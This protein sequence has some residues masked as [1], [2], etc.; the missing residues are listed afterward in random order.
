MATAP[1][2]IGP[3]PVVPDASKAEADFD[4]EYEDFLN[5]QKTVLTPGINALAETVFTNTQIAEAKANDAAD[6]ANLAAEQVLLAAEQVSLA[7]EQVS[8]AT[9]QSN[10]A[11]ISANFVGYWLDLTGALNKPASVSHNGKFYALANNLPNVQLSE[12]GISVDWVAIR[13]QIS[14]GKSFFFANL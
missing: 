12:P 7:A 9:A 13:A 8:L 5:W 2:P 14:V 6:K 3:A 1:I 10:L 11:A 4:P